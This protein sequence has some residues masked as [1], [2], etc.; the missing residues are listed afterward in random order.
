MHELKTIRKLPESEGRRAVAAQSQSGADGAAPSIAR[1]NGLF[2]Q[3]LSI[4][5]VFIGLTVLWLLVLLAEGWGLI[6]AGT[7]AWAARRALAQKRCEASRL[8]LFDPAA[9]AAPSAKPG[10][11]LTTAEDILARLQAEFTGDAGA[12]ARPPGRPGPTDS[13]AEPLRDAGKFVQDL[14]ERA[15]RAGVGIRPEEQFGII[16][17]GRDS[18]NPVAIAARRRQREA[19]DYLVRAL[20]AAHP[21]QLLSVQ[22]ACQPGPVPRGTQTRPGDDGGAT[23]N[24]S[25]V[26][27][28]LSVREAG[29]IETMSIRL[30]F[31]GRTAALRRFLNQL[32]AGPQLV[33]IS[34]IAVEPASTGA[35]LPQGKATDTGPVVLMVQPTL[36]QFTVT[37]ECCA[38]AAGLVTEKGTARPAAA[39]AGTGHPPCVWPEPRMQERGRGWIYDV[40]TPPALF[41]DRRSHALAAVPAEEATP[42][43]SATPSFDLQLLEVRRKP[44]WLRLVGFA[45]GPED[46]KG[47]FADMTTGKTVVGRVG[48]RLAGHQLWLKRLGLDRTVPGG[49]ETGAP[50]A[51]ATVTDEE[52]GEEISL[53][54][55]GP[56]PAGAPLGWFASRKNPAWRRELK[57]GGSTVVEGVRYCVERIELEPP[58]AVVTGGPEDGARATGRALTPQIPLD[59]VRGAPAVTAAEQVSR[60]VVT[61][62]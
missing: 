59:A 21:S 1:C 8:A 15:R 57:E 62:P 51:T 10:A 33:I 32:S 36:S 31:A 42:A 27:P 28:R 4:Q 56:S 24:L 19:T 52:T 13:R 41:H 7:A 61:N 25:D 47:I 14:R 37:V 48:D 40:F 17:T 45:G 6:D 34:E 38:L 3:L 54:T 11:E 26:D 35:S 30:T 43:D 53:T 46:L 60:E 49:K 58:L 18:G 39:P 22:C 23:G 50:L 20:L 9:T 29:E 12:S 55:R 5:R 44:F 16:Q 2:G